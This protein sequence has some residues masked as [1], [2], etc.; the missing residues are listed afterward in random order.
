MS[1]IKPK[2]IILL[3][4]GGGR[5]DHLFGYSFTLANYYDKVECEMI[6][7]NAKIVAIIKGGIAIL[8]S[9]PLL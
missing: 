9:F 8:R 7:N 6:T 3:G 5:V 4:A 2:K 1:Q